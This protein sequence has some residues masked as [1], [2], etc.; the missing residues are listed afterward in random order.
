MCHTWTQEHCISGVDFLLVHLAALNNCGRAANKGACNQAD[1]PCTCT[2]SCPDA[3]HAVQEHRSVV[4]AAGHTC[5]ARKHPCSTAVHVRQY[6]S[7]ARVL[8]KLLQSNRC[9]FPANI[10][11]LSSMHADMPAAALLLQYSCCLV[12][13]ATKPPGSS[14]M[15]LTRLPIGYQQQQ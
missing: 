3:A 5:A 6:T 8:G 1:S 15:P 14:A 10:F 7:A 11:E 12:R 9:T 4:Q 2:L 13:V